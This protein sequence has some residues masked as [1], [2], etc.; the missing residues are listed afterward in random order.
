MHCGR[1][2]FKDKDHIESE[3]DGYADGKKSETKKFVLSRD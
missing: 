1:I 3:W 2:V